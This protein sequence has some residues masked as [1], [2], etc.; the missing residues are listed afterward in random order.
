MSKLSKKDARRRRH[1]R[2][3]RKVAGT[4]E[5]PRMAV[6]KTANHIYV[7]LV[8]D[9]AQRTLVAASTLDQAWKDQ[10]ERANV[11]SAADLGRIVAERA[12]EAD[13]KKVIFD[14]GGFTYHGRIKAL[15]DAAREAGLTF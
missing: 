15:A 9:E 2:L 12:L 1:K 3:R 6:C 14:R 7:Q 4:P 11:E 8:D 13:I 5:R 10:H